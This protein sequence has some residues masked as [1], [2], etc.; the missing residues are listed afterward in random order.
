MVRFTIARWKRTR[1]WAVY[2]RLDA[3]WST[4]LGNDEKG[5]IVVC[6]YKKGALRL[7]ARLNSAHHFHT[8][9]KVFCTNTLKEATA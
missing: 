9:G 6:V 2:D 5:L 7:A 3:G 1:F 4:P 8:T